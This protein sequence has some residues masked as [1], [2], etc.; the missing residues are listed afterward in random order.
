MLRLTAANSQHFFLRPKV[1]RDKQPRTRKPHELPY[2]RLGQQMKSC[3]P[4]PPA[5]RKPCKGPSIAC[6]SHMMRLQLHRLRPSA[7]CESGMKRLL[8]YTLFYK[9]C[10]I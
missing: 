3:R 7:H 1:E 4:R 5:P 2:K 9:V 8:S 10:L 6:S